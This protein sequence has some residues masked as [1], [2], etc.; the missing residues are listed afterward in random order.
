M[1]RTSVLGGAAIGLGILGMVCIEPVI[2]LFLPQYGRSVGLYR[3]LMI[4]LL[5]QRMAYVAATFLV[6]NR[7]QQLLVG[8]LAVS[9]PVTVGLHL[10]AV[11]M[12][13]GVEGIAAGSAVGLS[14]YAVLMVAAALRAVGGLD[15]RNLTAM[16]GKYVSLLVVVVPLLLVAPG[17]FYI[18]LA[19]FLLIYAKENSELFHMMKAWRPV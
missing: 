17:H 9:V 19:A 5:A 1:R 8:L 15:V 6:A 7:R 4:G 11:R 16:F 10:I 3:I 14:F 13:W 18:A 2:T 12:G